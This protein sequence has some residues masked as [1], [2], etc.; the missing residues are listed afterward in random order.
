ME[1]GGGETC[2]DLSHTDVSNGKVLA[3]GEDEDEDE[4]DWWQN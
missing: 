1:T 2:W 4:D 3:T